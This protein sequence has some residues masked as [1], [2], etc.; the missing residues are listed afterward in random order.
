[1]Q[2]RA[3]EASKPIHSEEAVR[4]LLA[5]RMTLFDL[6]NR[7]MMWRTRPVIGAMASP[8]NFL[9]VVAQ[10]PFD[11]LAEVVGNSAIPCY[12]NSINTSKYTLLHHR[13]V[14]LIALGSLRHKEVIGS[15]RRETLMSYCTHSLRMLILLAECGDIYMYYGA[16]SDVFENL[17]PKLMKELCVANPSLSERLKLE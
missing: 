8:D 4:R 14:I 12:I 11:Y 10:S 13:L 2:Q 5:L 1:M 15:E 3:K 16:L 17:I 7:E 6:K 9:R